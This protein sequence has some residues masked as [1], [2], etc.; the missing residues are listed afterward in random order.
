MG[1]VAVIGVVD[2]V[3][4]QE[5]QVVRG[6]GWTHRQLAHPAPPLGPMHPLRPHPA[7]SELASQP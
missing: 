6:L 3:Y 1:V 4:E 5:M 2:V 7:I